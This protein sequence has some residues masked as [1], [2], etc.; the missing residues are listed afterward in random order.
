MRFSLTYPIISKTYDRSFLEQKNMIRFS[1]AAEAAGFDAM[2]FT[3]H[4]APSQEWLASGGHDALDPFAALA[5]CA[6]ATERIRLMPNIVVLPYRNPFVVAKA[7]STID[8]L[9][10]GRFTLSTAPGY[11]E[12]EYEG[13]GVSF[14]DRHSIFDESIEVMKGIWCQDDFRHEGKHFRANGLTAN[15]KPI[16]QPHPPIWIGGNSRQARR[17]V[18]RYAQGWNPFPASPRLAERAKTLSVQTPEQLSVLLDD[19]W[20]QVEAAGRDRSEIDVQ[21]VNR[22][23]G[24]PA[25]DDFDAGAHLDALHEL[26]AMGVT[27]TSVATPGDS[28]DHAIETLERY[29]KRV[30]AH[31]PRQNA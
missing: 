20:L 21:F 11:M 31:C 27:W 10:G 22:A 7:V 16:Q 5:F 3:D 2:G 8:V 26:A 12:A 6:A 4:P 1:Q 15:P 13:L 28:V 24:L 29:G 19:L 17:R 25:H 18:A 30:I 14:E 9:S 23:G